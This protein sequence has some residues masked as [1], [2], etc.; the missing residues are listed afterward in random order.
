MN[1][2][3][4]VATQEKVLPTVQDNTPDGLIALA[5]TQGADVDKLEKLF[6][7]REK[8]EARFAQ[9]AFVQAMANFQAQCPI[10]EKTKAVKNKHGTIVYFYAPLDVIIK[11]VAD[12]I[13]KNGLAYTFDISND[14]KALTAVCK[15]THTQGHSEVFTF[16][17][18]I[19]SEE[20]MTEVQKFGARATFAKRNAFCNAFGIMTGE[21]DTDAT[22]TDKEKRPV[23]VKAQIMLSLKALEA[24]ITNK[25]TVEAS[26][27]KLTGVEPV[28]GNFEEIRDRL[29]VLVSE[30]N[31]DVSKTI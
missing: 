28:D 5:L 2:K 22:Q 31:G 7:L 10:I 12:V 19:G 27:R 14:D 11:Q 16:K 4:E 29:D 18:P 3:T 1:K 6:A 21:E 26:I 30:R 25:A 23:D 9:S 20:Y 15:V 17:V 24:D 13:S 8:V